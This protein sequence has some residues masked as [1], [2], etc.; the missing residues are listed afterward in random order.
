MNINMVTKKQLTKIHVLL[1]QL[2][3]IDE[4]AELVKQITNGRETSSRQLTFNE[5]KSLLAHLSK[6]DPLDKMRRKVFAL[7]YEAGF[8]Y[9]NTLEDRQMNIA[10]LNK[11]LRV[12]GTVK[13]DLNRMNKDELIKVINQF[14]GI[15]KNNEKTA[16]SKC[17]KSVLNEI[18]IPT[19]K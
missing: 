14:T 2:G 4:K 1:N 3:V 9:G 17:A 7:A 19:V 8:I 15:L 12:S 5:A 13:K 10:K 16:A 6:F 18:G 11:F